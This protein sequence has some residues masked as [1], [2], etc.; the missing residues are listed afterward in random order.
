M[1]TFY[2]IL[3]IV[4]V[5]GGVLLLRSLMRRGVD[6]ASKAANQKILY[7]TEYEEGKQIVSEPIIFMTSA[8]VPEIIHELDTHV[9]IV[10]ATELPVGFKAAVYKSSSSANRIGYA[11]GNKLYP[12]TFEAEAVFAVQDAQ[13]TKCIFRILRWKERDGLIMGQEAMKKLSK[14]VQAAFSAADA[15]KILKGDL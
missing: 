7:K 4:A 15:N 1:T 14:E 8:S 10:D 12:Q 13:T 5:V 9:S 6:A 2:A 3:I 11:F